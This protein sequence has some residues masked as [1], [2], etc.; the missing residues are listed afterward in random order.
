MSE[1][2][3]QIAASGKSYWRSLSGTGAEWLDREFPE[4]AS[5]LDSASRRTLLK[6][7]AASFGLAGLTACSRP[8]E[9]ILPAAK[10]VEDQIPG[11]P[12]FY[13]TAMPLGGVATGLLVEAHDG[14]PTKV[15]GNPEHP[16]SGGVASAFH[17]ASVLGLYDPDRATRVEREGSASTWDEFARFAVGRF[18]GAGEGLRF[19]SQAVN[20]PSL[21]AVRAHAL[22]RFPQAKW[23]EYEPLLD[24]EALAGAELAFGSAVQPVWHFDKAAVVV[25]L[26]ADFLGLDAASI[27]YTRDFARARRVASEKDAMNRLYAVE[28][29]FSVTGAMADHRLRLRASEIAGFA[30]E[31]MAALE[32]K[33][34]GKWA[35]AVARDLKGNAGRSLVVAGPR[36]PAAVHAAAHAINHALGNAGKT[37][38]YV[39]APRRPQLAALRE[40]AGEM[41]AGRVSTLVILGGNPAYDAPADLAFARTLGKVPVSIYLGPEPNE[42]A[43]LAKWALPEAHYLEA[44]SDARA[45]DGTVSIVQPLIQPLY[46]GRTA[47]EVV[48]LISGYKDQRGYD[49]VRNFW[50]AKWPAAAEQTWRKCLH[51]GVV[52][53][54]AYP[55]VNPVADTKK[56]AA[57]LGALHVVNG[58]ELA[59]YPSSA[60]WDGRFANNGWLQEAPDPITKLTW[61]NAA[62]M[63]PATARKLG[64]ANGDLVSVHTAGGEIELPVWIQ[65]GHADNAVSVALGYGRARVGRV[66]T[67]VG[68]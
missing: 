15:E 48:A 25:A 60:T 28:G 23:V 19:L 40:L 53:E 61:D 55:A 35:T 42:T 9:K 66:G 27:T 11:N 49:I 62:L 32:G 17:Q 14:R 31:L 8:V 18:T 64:A 7:M 45:L 54:T 22:A 44:W 50:L 6:L 2:L 36:Q 41:A 43:A 34:A 1:K 52:P 51:D 26:D 4:A 24:D 30:A 65:P 56:V 10:G 46:G 57:A 58:V 16:F 20:S 39:A 12:L 3:Y 38:T 21:E 33:P 47:A 29:Q 63:S 68:R 37:V 67:G 5:E 13:A 59:F